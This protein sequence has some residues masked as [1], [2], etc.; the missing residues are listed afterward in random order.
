VRQPCRCASAFFLAR[1]IVSIF[2]HGDRVVLHPCLHRRQEDALVGRHPSD[3]DAAYAQVPQQEV[4]WRCEEC[5]VL[6]L[7]NDV[8]VVGRRQ[9]CGD[10]GAGPGAFGAAAQD[11]RACLERTV[12]PTGPSL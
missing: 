9:R 3:N 10:S 8:V 1:V 4:K 5:R 2:R 11:Q 12:V 6:G 7:E